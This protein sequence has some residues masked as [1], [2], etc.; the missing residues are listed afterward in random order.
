MPNPFRPRHGEGTT[1]KYQLASDASISIIIYDITGRLLWQRVY[2]A[3]SQ[4]GRI[5]FNDVL[6]NGINDFGD[7]VPNGAYIFLI[8]SGEKIL[9]KGQLAVAD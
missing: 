2:S 1:F 5:N 7:Y 3:G 6:W 4:G 9:V 8:T